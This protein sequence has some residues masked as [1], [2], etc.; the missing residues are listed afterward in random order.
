MFTSHCMIYCLLLLC[1]GKARSIIQQGLLMNLSRGWGG[2]SSI[3]SFFELLLK[4]TGPLLAILC[5]ALGDE[6]PLK[7][8]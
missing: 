7:R 8:E 5:V 6:F 2:M 4:H 1:S 3:S